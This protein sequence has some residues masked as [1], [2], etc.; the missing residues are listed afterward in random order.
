MIYFVQFAQVS[1]HK[2]AQVRL[3]HHWFNFD[4][5]LS[6]SYFGQPDK[7][8]H[9][10]PSL[11]PTPRPLFQIKV[12]AVDLVIILPE[13]DLLL[14]HQSNDMI[15]HDL[16]FVV[17]LYLCVLKNTMEVTHPTQPSKWETSFVCKLGT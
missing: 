1:K 12:Y 3:A 8:N 16:Q 11:L 9:I 13:R 10:G 7:M 4:F 14:Y 17:K 2:K 15:Y 5:F 6:L